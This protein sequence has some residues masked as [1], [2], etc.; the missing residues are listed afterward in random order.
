L[1]ESYTLV[2]IPPKYTLNLVRGFLHTIK[3]I[4]GFKGSR[5]ENLLGEIKMEEYTYTGRAF[6]CLQTQYRYLKKAFYACTALATKSS[7]VF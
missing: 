2:S 6:G 1:Q 5:I 7:I 4:L 3:W